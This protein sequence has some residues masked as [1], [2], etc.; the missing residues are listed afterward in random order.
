MVGRDWYCSSGHGGRG[1]MRRTRRSAGGHGT[2]RVAKPWRFRE[3]DPVTASSKTSQRFGDH[4]NPPQQPHLAQESGAAASTWEAV[5]KSS[6]RDGNAPLTT[7]SRRRSSRRLPAATGA[8]TN[9]TGTASRCMWAATRRRRQS[10]RSGRSS[11][12][13][14]ITCRWRRAICSSGRVAGWACHAAW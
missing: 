3:N 12:A 11:A 6:S 9:A 4:R 2:R 13:T 5:G 10:W 8:G 7:S 14:A 1:E